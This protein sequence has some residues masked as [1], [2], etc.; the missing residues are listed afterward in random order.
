M[1]AN[2]RAEPGGSDAVSISL[3]ESIRHSNK[4][5]RM[6][7]ALNLD[8]QFGNTTATT[9]GGEATLMSATAP[10]PTDNRGDISD[11]AG[12]NPHLSASA[13]ENVSTG[14]PHDEQGDFN[15]YEPIKSSWR[16]ANDGIQEITVTSYAHYIDI[17][18]NLKDTFN[19]SLNRYEIDY[20]FLG[21]SIR[22]SGLSSSLT[23]L[24]EFESKDVAS[25]VEGGLLKNFAR[26]CN[27]S[28]PE[29]MHQ[30][31]TSNLWALLAL[32]QHNGCPTRLLE[33]TLNPNVALYFAVE[34]QAYAGE[35]GEIWLV[36]PRD[37]A[38]SQTSLHN[39]ELLK[40]GLWCPTY[41]DLQDALDSVAPVSPAEDM[42]EVLNNFDA[43]SIEGH[44]ILNFFKPPVFDERIKNQ[45]SVYS[46]I[47]DPLIS[48]DKVLIDHPNCVVR[49][50]IPAF[51]KGVFLDTLDFMGVHERVL[52]PGLGGLSAALTRYFTRDARPSPRELQI[53]F[54]NR[55]DEMNAP[56]PEFE[57][58]N[59]PDEESNALLAH[60]EGSIVSAVHLDAC[61]SLDGSTDCN[62]PQ[63][64]VD[65]K[66]ANNGDIKYKPPVLSHNKS[67][68]SIPHEARDTATAPEIEM[69]TEDMKAAAA[70]K[71]VE[72]ELQAFLEAE[73]HRVAKQQRI[74]I[75]NRLEEVLKEDIEFENNEPNLSKNGKLI[76]QEIAGILIEYPEVVFNI[77]SHTY[78]P[79]TETNN[80]NKDCQMSHFSNMCAKNLKE[81]LESAGCINEFK[82]KGWG[83]EHPLLGSVRKV[84]VFPED[85]E[86]PVVEPQSTV[87]ETIA[88]DSMS[89]R[90]LVPGTPLQ[91]VIPHKID[92]VPESCDMDQPL[93]QNGGTSAP[94]SL[95]MMSLAFS[96]AS[97]TDS[98]NASTS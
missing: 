94:E 33:W 39:E 87:A 74:D 98:V 68:Q 73:K 44:P 22:G 30:S 36:K 69:N 80:C 82:I 67:L 2:Q 64:V 63:E 31:C 10:V 65:T 79:Q 29:L 41:T 91:S 53:L 48:A 16:V 57:S 97:D 37:L 19:P 77:E 6:L 9:T 40:Q 89:L 78:C 42:L 25:L 38:K 88:I 28:A 11:Q 86:A 50:I 54:S 49:M 13:D 62:Q 60:A 20:A 75:L 14:V 23:D 56:Q 17:I 21:S 83:C 72:G 59:S 34:N 52:F 85:I 26:F 8:E 76:C 43:L 4:R 96:A 51:V 58:E 32:M 71:K 55:R 84:R 93:K 47:S 66:V 12:Q 46:V 70:V 95:R 3:N 27:L 35:D 61:S 15:D 81:A 18:T 1:A 92:D 45:S 24:E 7:A 5:K 90:H